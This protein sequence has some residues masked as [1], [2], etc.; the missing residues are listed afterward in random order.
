L[1]YLSLL[2]DPLHLRDLP[3][4]RIDFDFARYIAQRQASTDAL[5]H[6]AGAYAYAGDQRVLRTLAR[7]TPVTLATEATVRLWKNVA[8]SEIL[9]TSVKV[10]EKQFAEIYQLT[11][12]CARKL[13]IAVPTVYIA[14]E[15][16]TLN[17]HTF[18]TNDDA[19]IVLN[20]VLV[21]HLSPAE[22]TFVIGHECGHIQNNHAVYITAL[23]Y[24]MYSAN[25]FV[26]WIIKP[27]VLALQSWA[28]RA[29]IT[30]DRAGLICCGDIEVALRAL[31]KLA[32]G[33]QKLADQ[34]DIEEYLK[35]LAE[36]QQ[37]VGRAA[38]LLHSHPYL[39]KRTVALQLFAET[40]FYHKTLG[41]DPP[42]AA[43]SLN[44]CDAEVAQIISI[45]GTR[46]PSA[47]PP[48]EDQE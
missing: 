31:V 23:H 14:P 22:L 8:R 41:G 17:A 32:L 20:G 45:F 10:T 27:A 2:V 37:G 5:A 29:E 9:G 4:P 7:I 28:R 13:Q 43:R 24:L 12:A 18:G 47:A 16:G 3:M 38:E 33:S 46:Q 19:Y 42:A 21:D 1:V 26:R 35:Q 48:E 25:L 40:H 34:L 30:C 44:S 15:V 11:A 6:T 39:P 36:S